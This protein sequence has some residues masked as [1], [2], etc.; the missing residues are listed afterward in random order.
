[1][2]KKEPKLIG[3]TYALAGAGA[4]VN[5]ASLGVYVRRVANRTSSPMYV[6]MALAVI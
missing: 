3:S 2:I 1:M 4:F 5:I 6:Q